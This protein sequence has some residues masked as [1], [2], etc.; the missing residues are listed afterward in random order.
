MPSL[1]K[2][3]NQSFAVT[4]VGMAQGISTEARSKP[5]PRN[6]LAMINAID[7][8]ITVSSRTVTTVK[9]NVFPID[10]QN[11]DPSVPGGQ[12]IEPLAVLQDWV[13]QFL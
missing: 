13:I 5:R 6:V 11:C 3:K 1:A 8:P 4:A 12:G 9:P 7:R 10:C 2:M